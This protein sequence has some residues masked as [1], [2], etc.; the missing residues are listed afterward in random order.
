ME[1]AN[2]G[3]WPRLAEEG[4]EGIR[5]VEKGRRERERLRAVKKREEKEGRKEENFGARRDK[6]FWA[7]EF[8][9][10]ITDSSIIVESVQVFRILYEVIKK[11]P[12][13]YQNHST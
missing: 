13:S 3:Y 7:S 4:H 11:N 5:E 9:P 8:V 12:I 10:T 6:S 1:K 2:Q